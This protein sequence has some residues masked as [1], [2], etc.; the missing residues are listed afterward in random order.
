VANAIQIPQPYWTVKTQAWA[1][2]DVDVIFTAPTGKKFIFGTGSVI[3]NRRAYVTI[4]DEAPIISADGKTITL[5]FF[6]YS[7]NGAYTPTECSIY[8]NALVIDE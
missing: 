4:M 8:L 6:T 2:G 1:T 5:K 3:D 7:L